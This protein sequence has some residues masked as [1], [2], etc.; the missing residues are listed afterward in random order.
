[1]CSTC[2][3]W[4]VSATP[5]VYSHCHQPSCSCCTDQ[6]SIMTRRSDA[7]SMTWRNEEGIAIITALFLT[8]ILSLIGSSLIVVAR[9]ETLSSLNYKTM[10]QARYGAESGVHAAANHL[11]HT[12]VPPGTPADPL[13]SY[14]MTVRP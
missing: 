8:L 2:G 1:M 11:L 3:R 13:T 10:S 14:D 4:P 7:S 9:S 6:E 12:Y 5:T